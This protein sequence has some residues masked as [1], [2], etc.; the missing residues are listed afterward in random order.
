[1]DSLNKT[2][3]D[4]KREYSLKSLKFLNTKLKSYGKLGQLCKQKCNINN[5]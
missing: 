3:N 5:N 4:F 1:M 2:N